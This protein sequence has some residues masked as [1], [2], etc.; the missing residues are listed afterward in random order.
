MKTRNGFISN[1]SSSSFVISKHFMTDD[2]IK[3]F[4]EF[5][6]N[7]SKIDEYEDEYY[8]TD[9]NEYYICGVGNRCDYEDKLIEKL[10]NMG[11]DYKKIYRGDY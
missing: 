10:V 8:F 9:E 6:N 2:Q 1:S 11:I 7:L 5:R 4:N 3:E